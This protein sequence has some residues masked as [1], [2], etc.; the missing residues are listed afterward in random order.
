[1]KSDDEGE[2]EEVRDSWGEHKYLPASA[3]V[4]RFMTGEVVRFARDRGTSG[5]KDVKDILKILHD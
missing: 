3:M 1:M 5:A 4:L 2:E